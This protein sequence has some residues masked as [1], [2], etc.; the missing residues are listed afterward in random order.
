ME[1]IRRTTLS[2]HMRAVALAAG[3]LLASL[4]LLAPAAG[5][6]T[7]TTSTDAYGTI[8]EHVPYGTRAR[9]YLDVYTP[10]RSDAPIVVFVHGGGWHVSSALSW[11][12]REATELQSQGFMVALVQYDIDTETIPAFVR[13]PEDVALATRWTIAN[14]AAY[15][16]NPH[17]VVLLGG[18]AGGQL[19]ASVA[20]RLD[21]ASA[22]TVRGVVTLSA[23]TN[24]LA[25]EG[26]IEAGTITDTEFIENVYRAVARNPVTHQPYMYATPW[27][28]ETYERSWS[29]ALTPAANCP[30]WLLFNSEAELIP[31]SQAQELNS[32]LRGAGCESTLQVVPGTRHAFGYWRTVAPQ[33]FSFIASL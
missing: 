28:Q 18:S 12:Q 14:A 11:F 6:A 24:F 32:A 10:T 20:E 4:A 30:R 15:G 26:L 1:V 19:V 33:V 17:D 13:E 22:G 3:A 2:L 16:G 31:L 8:Y 21:A 5:A 9:E 25:L 29:P 7:T 23:P 27:E